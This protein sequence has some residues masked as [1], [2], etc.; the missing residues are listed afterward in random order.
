MIMMETVVLVEVL[1]Y[2]P[3]VLYES[4]ILP[5]I[6]RRTVF[7]NKIGINGI[8]I[9]DSNHKIFALFTCTEFIFPKI[10]LLQMILSRN[11]LLY[12]K[13]QNYALIQ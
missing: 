9:C 6:K 1:S 4:G 5:H 2:D 13:C 3:K 7:P 10:F 8:L 11:Y 12:K